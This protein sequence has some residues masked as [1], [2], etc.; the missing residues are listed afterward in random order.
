M[1]RLQAYGRA[2]SSGA[3]PLTRFY[4]VFKKL[5]DTAAKN[6]IPWV[7]SQLR[8]G[9]VTFKWLLEE[10]EHLYG[11]PAFRAKALNS[12]RVMKQ[13]DRESFANFYPKFERELANARGSLIYDGI[14]V[15]FLRAALSPRFKGCLPKTKDYCVYEE[16]VS[17][18]KTAAVT[19]ANEEVIY[20]IRG[21]PLNLNQP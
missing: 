1:W 15:L 13:Q 19:M 10:L 16:L 11:D 6:V 7:S 2:I 4:A 8:A 5:K 14:K 3:D 18:L 17:D 12:V 20:G 21:S 9:A